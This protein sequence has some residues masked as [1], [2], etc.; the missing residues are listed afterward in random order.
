MKRARN[1]PAGEPSPSP[2][3]KPPRIK[4]KVYVV[5]PS[6]SER[7][8]VQTTS[9]PSAVRPESPSVSNTGQ[10]P[11]GSEAVA[12][13]LATSGVAAR[14]PAMNHATAAISRLR[15]T[16]TPVAVTT[17]KLRSSTKPAT[18]QPTTAPSVLPP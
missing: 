9:E 14:D 13:A 18:R 7:M 10:L 11:A 16:A 12:R 5:G 4:E 15:H 3:R 6:S 17:S 8:R 2:A 1:A